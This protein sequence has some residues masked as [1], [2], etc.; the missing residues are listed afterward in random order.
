MDKCLVVF[1]ELPIGYYFI[2]RCNSETSKGSQST[3]TNTVQVGD[4]FIS[5]SDIT[6]SEVKKMVLKN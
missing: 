4:M 5:N 1:A 2:Y 3:I 6:I